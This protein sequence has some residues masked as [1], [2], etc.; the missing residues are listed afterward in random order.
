MK[1]HYQKLPADEGD[2]A[3][4][5]PSFSRGWI[6]VRQPLLHPWELW[7]FLRMWLTLKRELDRSPG[8]IAFEYRLRFRPFMIGMHVV[9]RSHADE[10]RFYTESSHK[11]VSQWSFRSQLTPALRLE[12]F[13]RDKKRRLVRL[14]GFRVYEKDTDL[15]DEI[16]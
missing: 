16:H 10:M 2:E 13:V 8:L 15:P 5:G 3:L 7:Q 1:K 4:S 9:W 6:R 11:V 12:H 14:G